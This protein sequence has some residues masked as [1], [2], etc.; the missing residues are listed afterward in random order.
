MHLEASEE[1]IN[2]LN[3]IRRNN[4]IL[5]EL[6]EKQKRSYKKLA[7]IS[8]I[9]EIENTIKRLKEKYHSL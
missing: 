7:Y 6:Y 8:Q 4:R 2:L 5:E 9:R 3:Y 1:K